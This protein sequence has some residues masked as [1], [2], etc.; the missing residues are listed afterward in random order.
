LISHLGA[1]GTKFGGLERVFRAPDKSSGS[2]GD[3]Q[4]YSQKFQ[5]NKDGNLVINSPGA[6]QTPNISEDELSASNGP[7]P[8]QK[9]EGTSEEDG[10]TV[11]DNASGGV[12]D[13]ES[14]VRVAEYT[15]TAT[16][17]EVIAPQSIIE[18]S[19]NNA[20]QK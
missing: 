3:I 13:D 2:E 11:T 6:A 14:I 5:V 18:E 19:V 7:P 1:E 20:L 9:K 12:Y 4:N 16:N 15:D 10:E 8:S 17:P